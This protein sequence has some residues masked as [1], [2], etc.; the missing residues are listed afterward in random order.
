MNTERERKTEKFHVGDV[1]SIILGRVV[2][3]CGVSGVLE[4][5]KFMSGKPVSAHEVRQICSECKPQLLEQ[6]PQLDAPEISVAARGELMLMLATPVGRLNRELLVRSWLSKVTSG[7]YG[8]QIDAIVN[9][10]V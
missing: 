1:L 10:A 9:V 2:S 5:L 3:P 7:G 6:F 4:I 8:V